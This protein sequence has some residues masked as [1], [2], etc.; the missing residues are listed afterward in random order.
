MTVFTRHALPGDITGTT[1]NATTV[2][3]EFYQYENSV[4]LN[5]V[6]GSQDSSV[7]FPLESGLIKFNVRIN[8]WPF[9]NPANFLM[10]QMNLVLA[11]TGVSAFES[12]ATWGTLN[13][14][15]ANGVQVQMEVLA[16]SL[17]DN[18]T[19]NV[20]TSISAVGNRLVLPKKKKKKQQLAY[21]SFSRLNHFF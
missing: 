17:N 19:Q 21:I 9:Q 14:F 18:F 1:T 7:L 13:K 16:F 4:T 5:G 15:I 10:L 3:F 2:R 12:T 6:P 20:A 11:Q 8:N